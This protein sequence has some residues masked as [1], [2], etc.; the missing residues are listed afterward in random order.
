Q[1]FR[2]GGAF[3]PTLSPDGRWLVYGTRH[4]DQTGL[5][6]RDLE[7]GD[8]RWLAFPV[9]RDEQE[10]VASRDAYPGMSFTPDSK[11]VVATYGGRIWRIPVDG[12]APREIPF[13]VDVKLDLGPRV[14]FDYPVDDSPTFT[15][16]QIADAVPSPDGGRLAFTALDKLYVVD[17]NV[18][19]PLKASDDDAVSTISGARRLTE[20]D[21]FEHMPAWSPDGRWIAYVTWSEDEGG[22]I[23]RVRADGRG[24]AERLTRT[25]AL[26]QQP[27][28][29]PDGKRIVA[30][31][32]PARAYAEAVGPW[33]PGS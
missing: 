4:V 26:Y 3:R 22:H 2:I 10:S 18:S 20:G 28:W 17:L 13:E 31:R 16:R 15:V 14:A 25:P 21:R 6:I 30:L 32:G 19:E 11:E 29:S 7:T 8:E 9:Q 12:S 5:R 24:K 27:V 1:S 23:Y 33:A